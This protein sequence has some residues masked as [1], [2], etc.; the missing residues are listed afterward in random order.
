MPTQEDCEKMIHEAGNNIDTLKKELEKMRCQYCEK[1]V[2]E[3][4][5][6]D[7]LKEKLQQTIGQWRKCYKKVV[8]EAYKQN[9]PFSPQIDPETRLDSD[10]RQIFR[11]VKYSIRVGNYQLIQQYLIDPI[12][13]DEL[14]ISPQIITDIDSL[15]KIA[16]PTQELYFEWTK[17]ELE[18]LEKV[19]KS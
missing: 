6:I 7:T 19:K 4:D 8:E 10:I 2:Y 18:R 17:K 3:A 14:S 1:M 12:S 5:N 15:I 11:L 9:P 16:T 13:N